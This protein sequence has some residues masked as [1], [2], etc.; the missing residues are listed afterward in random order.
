MAMPWACASGVSRAAM[1]RSG[2]VGAASLPSTVMKWFANRVDEPLAW[3]A[4]ALTVLLP[5][6]AVLAGVGARWARQRERHDLSEVFVAV[7]L[8]GFL[9]T[10]AWW[11]V[12]A[13]W[14][15]V[16]F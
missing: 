15:G 2:S 1:M 4:L 13:P 9:G 12:V 3:V 10:L 11:F 6:V 14:N 5:L 8:I 7:M 16:V